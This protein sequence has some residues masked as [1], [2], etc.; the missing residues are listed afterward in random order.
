MQEEY[1]E[2]IKC[3]ELLLAF[4]ALESQQRSIH[5]QQIQELHAKTS[6]SLSQIG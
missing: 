4:T 3:R 1:K 6:S 5:I 2:L